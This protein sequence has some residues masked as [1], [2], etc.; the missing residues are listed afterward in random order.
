MTFIK[1]TKEE[2][3]S[4]PT[5][6][7]KCRGCHE[8]L[9]FSNF[10][11]NKNTLFGIDTKCKACRRPVSK[12]QWD[13]EPYV[14]GMLR[15]A[16]TR[17]KKFDREFTITLDDIDIPDT[18]PIL[19]VEIVVE[20]NHPYRPSI[21]RIDSSRGYTPDNIMV[22]S[23]RGNMLKNNMTPEESILVSKFLGNCEVVDLR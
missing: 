5:K 9:P 2:I 21:D 6:H 12:A 7:K 23:F 8:V 17:S 10:G 14:V 19:G 1:F 3:A 13:A 15:A 18:C 11:N 4:W 16:K 20:R 22:V